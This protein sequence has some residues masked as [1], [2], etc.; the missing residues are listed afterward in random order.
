MRTFPALL[1]AWVTLGVAGL[2]HSVP[3]TNAHAGTA[4]AAPEPHAPSSAYQ[5]VEVLGWTLRVHDDL[6]A[7]EALYDRV[8]GEVHHQLFRLTRIMPEEALAFLRTVTI[9]I[10][11][12]NPRSNSCQ[13][14]PSRGWLAGNGYLPEKAH[15]IELSN[16]RSFLR[17]TQ[18]NQPYVLLH[19][20]AHA[21]HHQHLGFEHPGVIDC[22]ER[23]EGEGLY[24]QVLFIDGR[25]VRH[26]A[27]TD[28]KEYFAEATE[29]FFGRN[30]FYPFVEGELKEY[31]PRCYAL[32]AGLWG[33]ERE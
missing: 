15:G 27:L 17:I 11:L 23:A 25:T 12:D 21:Y 20:L 3:T 5:A 29:A 14:H 33:V 19:E 30:D 9:W 7:N 26:Y 18:R 22:F 28:H 31:D 16:A 2:S 6:L 32:I 1:F 24:E 8:Y 4:D 13:Y 10:E